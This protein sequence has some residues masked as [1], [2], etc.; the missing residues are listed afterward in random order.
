MKCYSS[1]K[2]CQRMKPCEHACDLRVSLPV[3]PVVKYAS[4]EERVFYEGFVSLD[5]PTIRP[6]YM[7]IKVKPDYKLRLGRL[8]YELHR[9]EVL[10]EQQCAGI[11]DCDL[12]TWRRM[13]E[14]YEAKSG[15]DAASVACNSDDGAAA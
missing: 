4:E 2:Q 8:L 13:R 6:G 15:T 1:M 14:C 3:M 10:S 5:G 9:D 7:R 11:F 12:V